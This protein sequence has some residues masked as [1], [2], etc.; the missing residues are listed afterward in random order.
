MTSEERSLAAPGTPETIKASALPAGRPNRHAGLL[1]A[2]ATAVLCLPF[3]RSVWWVSD[4]GIWL[5]AAQR[6]IG[7]QVL[8]RDFFEFYPPLGF[9]IVTGW[10]TLFGSSL[11]AARL[12]I[13]LVIALTAWFTFSCC[14]IMS[15]RVG[16]SAILTLAWVIGSQGPWTQVNHQWLSSLFSVMAL[17]AILSAEGKTGRL[18]LAGLAASA[19]TLVTT[20]RGGL[21]ALAGLAALLSRRSLKALLIYAASGLALL[22]AVLA[23]L[24]WQGSIA[25]VFDQVILF[26]LHQN[27]AVM[28][29]SFGAFVDQQTIF[30]VA[31]FPLAACLLILGLWRH[32]PAL[33]RRP[34]WGTA[35][36][37]ALA[38][39]LGC[40][41]RPDAVH[42]SFAVVLG[43]P[44]LAA[45]ISLL[46]PAGRAKPIYWSLAGAILLIPAYPL[47]KAA[48][49]A[50]KAQQVQTRAGLISLVPKNGTADI[51][52]RLESLPPGDSVFF[53]PYDPMLP[54]L[55]GR[56]HPAGI[57]IL[58]PQYSTA[59]QYLETCRQVMREAKW[60]SFNLD[61]SR[62]A[63]Y[64]AIFPAMSNPQPPETLAFEAALRE[65]FAEAA[66]DGHFQLL[67]RTRASTKLC[68]QLETIAR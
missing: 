55:T 5:H 51:M 46:W 23:L 43:L 19:A 22:A 32:G 64:R 40:F 62:P 8:Y 3:L 42:N 20:H 67:R 30:I 49:Q 54:Y 39:F 9:L 58:V 28:R 24:W 29:V 1:V 34:H 14:R 2:L 11:L 18:A 53:Y 21:V 38:G 13:V 66:L 45:L 6:V 15:N 47:V 27:A 17:W 60:V 7:G 56:R 59:A 12:L 65:G 41:P 36:L 48:L 57:D 33:L 50:G 10:T 25:T 37:F 26:P 31:I 16:V 63:F 4:E 44:L 61:V 35:G 52:H 68:R